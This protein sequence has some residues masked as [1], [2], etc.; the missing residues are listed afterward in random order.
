MV[1]ASVL[2]LTMM[3]GILAVQYELQSY[4][5]LVLQGLK[6]FLWAIL[7]IVIIGFLGSEEHR[8]GI[9]ASVGLATPLIV[10]L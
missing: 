1:G 9:G 7:T 4:E 5:R 6:V 3:E 10:V 8:L 2:F